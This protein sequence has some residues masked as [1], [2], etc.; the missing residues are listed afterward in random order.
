MKSWHNYETNTQ[1]IFKKSIY[2]YTQQSTLLSEKPDI[3][4]YL[5]YDSISENFKTGKKNFKTESSEEFA[6][7]VGG[8]QYRPVQGIQVSTV[9][10]YSISCSEWYLNG[11]ISM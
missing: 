10:K 2:F 11:C 5:L 7:G 4:D 6:L 3:K 1:I 8:W 9:W